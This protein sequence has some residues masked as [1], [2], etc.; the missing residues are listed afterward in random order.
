MWH[1]KQ[2]VIWWAKAVFHTIMKIIFIV[3]F[4]F[5]MYLVSKENDL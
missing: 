3:P 4:M 5:A 2:K 1:L